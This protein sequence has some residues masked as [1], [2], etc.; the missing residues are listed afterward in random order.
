[1]NKT[2]QIQSHKYMFD[3]TEPET[4]PSVFNTGR[5]L[6]KTT[7]LIARIWQVCDHA[8]LTAT[9][10]LYQGTTGGTERGS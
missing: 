8:C 2:C 3:D 9:V 7:G 6:A 10:K 1:M 4:Q 5:C